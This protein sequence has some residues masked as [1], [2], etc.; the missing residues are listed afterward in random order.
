ME[1]LGL[2]TGK[3][4]PCIKQGPFVEYIESFSVLRTG[5]YDVLSL[6]RISYVQQRGYHV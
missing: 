1:S 4:R 3:K 2:S 5:S 6:Y